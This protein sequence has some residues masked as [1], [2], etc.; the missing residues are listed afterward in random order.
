MRAF[1]RARAALVGRRVVVTGASSGV[2]AAFA[3]GVAGP[4]VRLVLV[5][6]RRALLDEVA[7]DAQA[8]GAE[9]E[10]SHLNLRDH[11]RVTELGERLVES[12]VPDVVVC[13]AAH[14]IR[15]PVLDQADRLHDYTR[16]AASNYTGAVA[17]LLPL[18][19]GMVERGSGHIIGVGTV[20]AFIPAPGWAAYC[21]S[22][23]AF[24]TWLRCVRPELIGHGVDVS[25]LEL[26][27]VATPMSRPTYGHRP[28]FAESPERAA[29]RIASLV[30]RPRAVATPGWARVAAAATAF[31]PGLSGRVMGLGAPR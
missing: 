27:L 31:A 4:G 3:R 14:S 24:E 29:A 25:T 15:R 21:A 17:L 6:R 23:A 5:A 9:V 22:K 30:V 16:T 18:L 26:A 28:W 19:P 2:G 20:S 13:N 10:V 12:G 11:A 8:A 1:E 7:A